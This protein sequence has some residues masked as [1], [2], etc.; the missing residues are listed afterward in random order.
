MKYGIQVEYFL[1][2]KQQNDLCDYNNF[3]NIWKVF[4]IWFSLSLFT[5]LS[6]TKTNIKEIIKGQSI[7]NDIERKHRGNDQDDF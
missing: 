1:L 3:L 5:D 2:L 7:K 4:Q 6:D